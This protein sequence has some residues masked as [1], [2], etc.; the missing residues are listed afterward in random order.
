[1]QRLQGFVIENSNR[2]RLNELLCDAHG[3]ERILR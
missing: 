1:M 2:V 3:S